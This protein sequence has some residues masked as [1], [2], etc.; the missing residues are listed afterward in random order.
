MKLR[1][2]LPLCLALAPVAHAGNI[3][4]T[5]YSPPDAWQPLASY[6]TPLRWSDGQDTPMQTRAYYVPGLKGVPKA[7]L[8]IT[9]TDG[10]ARGRLRWV[11]EICP[12]PRPKYFARDYGS[13]KQTRVREC[14][15]VNSAFAPFAYFKPD[16][17]V[18]RAAD[19][20]GI[21]L[22]KSGYSFRSVYGSEAG[23]LLFVNLMTTKAFKGLANAPT[24]S[25]LNDVAPSLVAM[26]EAL[27]AAVKASVL[28][29]GGQL[30]LPPIPLED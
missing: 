20:K 19:E 22:F 6:V 24:E 8:V 9:S 21:K 23:T 28:S 7:V 27:H 12:E 2:I 14:L 13:N 4:R 11:S 10:T 5:D 26:G 1:A 3:G 30:T 29:V 16:A 17:E 25:E 18:L 15:I